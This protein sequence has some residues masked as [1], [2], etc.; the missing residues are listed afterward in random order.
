MVGDEPQDLF[1][2]REAGVKI[3][4]VAQTR[5]MDELEQLKPDI[6]V[7]TLPE[8]RTHILTKMITI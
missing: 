4:L 2:A 5:N 7:H 3:A 1:L 8:L 6:L